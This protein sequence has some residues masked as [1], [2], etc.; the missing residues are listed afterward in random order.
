MIGEYGSVGE[1]LTAIKDP[2]ALKGASVFI[3]PQ[4]MVEQMSGS[5]KIILATDENEADYPSFE[6]IF[7]PKNPSDAPLIMAKFGSAMSNRKVQ[8][9]SLRH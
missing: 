6:V 9:E 8:I 3:L 2:S 5:D 4:C 1:K 7:S